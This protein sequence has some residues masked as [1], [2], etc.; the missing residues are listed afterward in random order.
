M[1]VMRVLRGFLDELSLCQPYPK[2]SI[3]SVSG[4]SFFDLRIFGQSLYGSFQN[5]AAYLLFY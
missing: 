5:E 3:G 2:G 4:K 1:T